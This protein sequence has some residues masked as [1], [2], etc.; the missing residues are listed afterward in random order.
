M[1][2]W[3]GAAVSCVDTGHGISGFRLWF[4]ESRIEI[5]LLKGQT[6]H[7]RERRGSHSHR[8]SGG[9]RHCSPS[10][11]ARSPGAWGCPAVGTAREPP[12]SA[13]WPS[14]KQLCVLATIHPPRAGKPHSAGE[15]W[16]RLAQQIGKAALVLP[17]LAVGRVWGRVNRRGCLEAYYLLSTR[18]MR[19]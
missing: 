16:G 12:S 6:D 11:A 2:S 4:P 1:C 5:P 3:P 15:V 17:A 9:A 14:Q 8:R 10:Q 19:E 13:V 7:T 18:G